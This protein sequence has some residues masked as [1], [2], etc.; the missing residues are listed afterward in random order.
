MQH[1]RNQTKNYHQIEL[2]LILMNIK[3][4]KESVGNLLDTPSPHPSWRGGE[5]YDC[6][7]ITFNMYHKDG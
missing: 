3:L 7:G 1:G 4:N 5:K 2:I 6:K